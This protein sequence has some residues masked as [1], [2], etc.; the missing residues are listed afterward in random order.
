MIKIQSD[1]DLSIILAPPKVVLRMEL[2]PAE[3]IG[4]LG[5]GSLSAG[6]ARDP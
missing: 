1:P 2:M 4:D 6:E 3:D 5:L